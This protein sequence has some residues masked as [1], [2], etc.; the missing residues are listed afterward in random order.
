[1]VD[2]LTGIEVQ[3]ADKIA[4]GKVR[5]IFDAG[6][7]H[8]IIVTTDRISAFDVVLPDPIPYKGY[9]LNLMSLFWFDMIDGIVP[10]H[11]VTS[12]V[13]KYPPPFNSDPRLSGRSML[14]R[15][16]EPLPVECVVRGYLAGSGWRE[17]KEKGSICGIGL[18][19]G[20]VESQKL[21]EPL[22]TPST[23]ESPGTHDENIDFERAIYIVGKDNAERIRDLS[24][25]IYSMAAD[26]A[27]KKGIIIADT[28]FEFGI[29]DGELMIIDEVLTPDSSRFWS[30][31]TFKPGIPQPS[32]DK[33]FVRDY[34]DTLN[35]D[36][37]S[38]GPHLPADVIEKTVKKYIDAYEMI[39][40]SKFPFRG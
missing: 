37:K 9:V 22:F 14:V 28:K 13:N 36:K 33:Q 5:E 15:K 21:P 23:K 19:S 11:V 39:T 2:V 8:M 30:K 29:V 27:L 34:L 7:D 40:G 26:F 1:M 6:D 16:A 18:P 20:M 10:N 17:Y 12:D 4:S 32:F 31:D 38:P 24:I 35:W 3:G 25:K